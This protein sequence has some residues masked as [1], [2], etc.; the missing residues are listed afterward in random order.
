MDQAI[1]NGVIGSKRQKN[2][3]YYCTNIAT[4]HL[5]LIKELFMQFTTS[6]RV[7]LLLITIAFMSFFVDFSNK[8]QAASM[9]DISDSVIVV[10]P[11][12]LPNSEQAAATTLLEEVESRTGIQWKKQSH[13]PENKTVIA[14]TSTQHKLSWKQQIP[15]RQDGNLPELKPEGFRLYVT[16]QKNRKP[17]IWIQGSD[18]R[19]TLF[20]VG[21]LLRNLVWA[22]GKALIP[23]NMDISKAP[24]Y[25][26]R[27]HQLGY[28]ARANS[29]DAWSKEEFDQH[30]RELAIFGTNAIEN[31]PFQD[32]R[33]NKFMKYSRRD[34]NKI[35]SDIC[36]RYGL[37]YWV[38][39]PAEFDLN[40]QVLRKEMLEKHETL[41][42]DCKRLNGVFF[43][44]GDPGDNPSELVLP[45]LEDVAKR[46]VKYHPETRIWLSLQRLPKKDVLAIFK[47]IKEK[48]PSWLGG[49]V[50]G[51]S[52][53][54]ISLIR[55]HLPSKYKLR[56][57]PDITHNKLC[58]YVVPW[59]DPAYALTLGREAINPRPREYAQI[60]NMFAPYSDGFISYTDG[61]HDDVNKIVWSM[62]GFTPKQDVRK[63]LVEY[64]KFFFSPDIAEDAADGILALE[65]NWQGSLADNGAVEGTLLL[66]DRLEKRAPQL[67]KNWRWQMNLLRANYDAFTRRRLL[68]ETELEKKSN[69]ILLKAPEIGADSALKQA[70]TVLNKTVAKPCSPK[71]HARIE[72]L[73]EELFRSISLQTSVD[74][75]HASGAERGAILDFVDYPLNNRWWLED[76]FTQ[77]A[78]LSTEEDKLSQLE[79][80][81]KWENPGEGSFYDDIGNI[82]KSPHV[83]RWNPSTANPATTVRSPYPTYWWLD[84][85]K[86]RARLS[87]QIT[88][89]WNA[90]VV[91]EGLLPYKEYKIR[92]AGYGKSLLR[93][94]GILLKPSLDKRGFGEFKEFP[95][96][97]N[98]LEDRK[99]IIT[100][101][102]P[103][104][105]DHLPWRQ[106]SRNAEIW[107]LKQ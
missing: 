46:L 58:Q 45:F 82:A 68:Y 34:M 70:T 43:P 85:G 69:A 67:S 19:G 89:Q 3:L 28:R 55:K 76:R 29:W 14:I 65:K 17:V 11:G 87:W 20:G 23:T 60:H 4:A 99:L 78:K 40:D 91:Y 71:L 15:K 86:S 92:V 104:D 27:G 95:V 77:I 59:W 98:L 51:P 33:R 54:A 44:A 66:W 2:M 79:M 6:F 18:S 73:C 62:L 105:E 74:L 81:A 100:W 5:K 25:S 72:S 96:P 48:D 56:L 75:Y 41:Y 107:L 57:Y 30:I 7:S 24:A 83:L 93:A 10:R 39:T 21:E 64:C 47:Y 80:I 52:S 103:T 61:V 26:I 22:K 8:V 12:E 36:D 53:P 101:D 37:D 1:I 97:K 49:L 31:I 50:A 13:W 94:D 9:I 16:Y 90:T 32:S 38:W 106:S 102:R 88:M 35:M 63:I 42:R 84:N